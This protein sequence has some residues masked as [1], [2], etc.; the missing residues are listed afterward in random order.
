MAQI[1]TGDL[2]KSYRYDLPAWQI[3]KPLV[4]VTIELAILS[5]D[6]LDRARRARPA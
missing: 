6:R 1:F 3:I 5:H 4:P 2:G